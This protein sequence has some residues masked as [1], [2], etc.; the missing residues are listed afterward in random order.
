V[1]LVLF[2]QA[3]ALIVGPLVA[4][5]LLEARVDSDLTWRLLLGLGAPPAT[6]CSWPAPS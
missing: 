4:L 6:A 5:A 1:G 2:M 3:L